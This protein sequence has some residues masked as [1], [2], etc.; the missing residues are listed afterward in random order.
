M[1]F[2][3]RRSLLSPS[4]IQRTPNI[5]SDFTPTSEV[6]STF[7]KANHSRTPQNGR[8]SEEH[9]GSRKRTF[10][11]FQARDLPVQ[12]LEDK[13]SCHSEAAP[14]DSILAKKLRKNDNE[15]KILE[16]VDAFEDDQFYDAIDLDAVEEQ[17]AKL[18]RQRSEYPLQEQTSNLESMPPNFTVIGS[19]SF[20]LGI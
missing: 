19:P 9:E 5:S 3:I 2:L 16:Y 7:G 11:L 17:A 14:K 12:N 15:N 20:D 10:S 13:F 18:L 1:S 6:S 4:P 8:E